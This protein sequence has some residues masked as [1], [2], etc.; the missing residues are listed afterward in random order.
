MGRDPG[1]RPGW[2]LG[3]VGMMVSLIPPISGENDGK[4]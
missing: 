4:A 3:V 1:S 2:Q